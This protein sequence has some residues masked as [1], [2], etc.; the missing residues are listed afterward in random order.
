M[1]KNIVFSGGGFK[2]ISYIG[3]I[4]ALKEYDMLDN[5][6]NYCGTSI[7][8][9]FATLLYINITY[10]ELYNIF[11]DFD[12]NKGLSLDLE[13]IINFF[14]NYGIDNGTNYINIFR[15]IISKKLNIDFNTD[16][17]F[18]EL[19][20]IFKKKLIITGVCVN[21]Y[22]CE[23]FDYIRTPY[24]SIYKALQISSAIPIFFKPIKFNN[25]LYID[26]GASN[27]FPIDLFVN[28]LENT[29]GFE[30]CMLNKNED[31]NGFF[32]YFIKICLCKNYSDNEKNMVYNKYYIKLFINDIK[33]IDINIPKEKR[34]NNINYGYDM[35]VKYIQTRFRI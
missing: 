24:M 26:G 30:I 21:N 33:L 19:F 14:D 7:G 10:D 35:T 2:G 22:T 6:E 1:I 17:T 27:N 28:D 8:S 13:N 20:N 23:Y 18:I 31:I 16:V 29:I 32:D 15:K 34:I 25:K 12:F 4:K 9:I 11:I 5:I 3:V